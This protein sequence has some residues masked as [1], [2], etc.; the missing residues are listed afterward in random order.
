[1]GMGEYGKIR[2]VMLGQGVRKKGRM[3]GDKD[4]R[5]EVWSALGMGGISVFPLIPPQ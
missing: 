2:A 5:E 1:M 3:R 4:V